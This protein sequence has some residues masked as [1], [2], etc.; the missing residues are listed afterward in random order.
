[1]ASGRKWDKGSPLLSLRAF[2]LSSPVLLLL[3]FLLFS[4]SS[5][6]AKV[7]STTSAFSV[8]PP[9]PGFPTR[10]PPFDCRSCPQASPVFASV[11]EGVRYPFFYSIADL[12]ALPGNPHGEILRL[13]DGKPYS[14]PDISGPIQEALEKIGAATRGLVVDVGGNVGMAIFAAAAMGRRVVS[15]EPVF[16]NLQRICDGV[17]LNRAWDRVTLFAAAASDHSGNITFHKLVGRLDNS[18][19]SA[20]GAKMTFQDKAEIAIEVPTIPLDDVIPDSEEVA[21][22]KIDV[23]GWEYHVL[24]GAKKILSR[25]P[26][27]AP[28]LMYEED[29]RLL[30]A[31]NTSAQ[32][33]RLF[34]KSVGYNQCTRHGGDTHCSKLPVN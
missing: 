20:T 13:L 24:R 21:L 27:R 3:L 9:N 31:S 28:F 17:F 6:F 10:I 34:L 26:G 29:E 7:P 14:A 1:M 4:S 23:Q 25:D 2:L 11:V 32:E 8:P 18:A 15:F 12:G 16:E 19:V 33:I 22:I 30:S 5:P